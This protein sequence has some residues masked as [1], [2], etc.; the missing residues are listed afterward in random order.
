LEA[1]SSQK[2]TAKLLGAR[3]GSSFHDEDP[4]KYFAGAFFLLI[5]GVI[6]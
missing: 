2:K 1:S 6:L 3:V 5:T 4:A